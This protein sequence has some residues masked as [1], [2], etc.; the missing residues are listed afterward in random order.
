[1]SRLAI[2]RSL[3]VVAVLVIALVSPGTPAGAAA[4]GGGTAAGAPIAR[5][6]EGIAYD[7]VRGQLLLFGGTDDNHDF[8][9]TWTWDG[10]AWTKLTPAH[11]PQKRFV[12]GMA[13]DAADGTVV[14]F[15]GS[16]VNHGN[17]HDTWVWDGTDW[18]KPAPA[19]APSGRHGLSMAY[20]SARGEVVLFGGCCKSNGDLWRDTWT[21]DGSDW[22]KQT[23]AHRPP[24]RSWA[25]MSDD[26]AHGQVVLFGGQI[27]GRDT[28][29]TWTWNGTDWTKHASVHSPL[30]RFNSRMTDD[31]AGHVLLF[32][33][34]N[35]HTFALGDTWS[36]NG[37]DW[38]E[39]HP[40]HTP[41]E[42]DGHGFAHDPASGKLVLFGGYSFGY[43]GDTWTWDGADWAQAPDGS[44]Q[45]SSHSGAPGGNVVVSGT[46]FLAGE[47]VSLRFVDSAHGSVF[48]EKVGTNATGGFEVNFKIPDDATPGSQRVKATGV[49]SGSTAKQGFTVT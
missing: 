40:A 26:P 41:T 34:F 30:R 29:S 32:G 14:L 4:S 43:S 21:W 22:T 19:H 10:A 37:T 25:S 47:K 13:A 20:D 5:G 33:G 2:V 18:T 24:R 46:G 23:P 42:R 38:T 36:W 6:F 39:L 44:I 27:E 12:F 15:G 11:A 16:H 9:D 31:G 3:A 48:V 1:M 45:L 49:D 35:E 17:Y 28:R 8:A 7:S